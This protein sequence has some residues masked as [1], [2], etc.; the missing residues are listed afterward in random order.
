MPK[1]SHQLRHRRAAGPASTN[2]MNKTEKLYF[3]DVTDIPRST[4]AGYEISEINLAISSFAAGSRVAAL[5]PFYEY[6]RISKLD[7][8]AFAG[9][10]PCS[11]Q[12]TAAMTNMDCSTGLGFIPSSNVDFGAVSSFNDLMQFPDATMGICG[13]KLRLRLGP[14]QLYG[15][16]PVK[17]FHTTV[18]GTP[19]LADSSVGTITWVTRMSNGINTAPRSY[20]VVKGVMEF[21]GSLIG[22]ASVDRPMVQDLTETKSVHEDYS[23]VYSG[24]LPVQTT[25]LVPET[26]RASDLMPVREK[27]QTRYPTG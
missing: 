18:T 10:H 24:G 21:K 15:A 27:V 22:S 9:W 2:F 6:F 20:V 7:V 13:S 14:R 26:P 8:E 23:V 11:T 3:T 12:T 17:W 4:S 19:P 1:K 5:A 16:T 25:R